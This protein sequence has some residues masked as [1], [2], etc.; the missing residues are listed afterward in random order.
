MDQGGEEAYRFCN[1]CEEVMWKLTGGWACGHCDAGGLD[2][3]HWMDDDD[4]ELV[5]TGEDEDE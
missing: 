5:E 2:R 1:L 4:D 3:P